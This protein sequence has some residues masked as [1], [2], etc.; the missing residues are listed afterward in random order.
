VLTALLAAGCAQPG[1]VQ[2]GPNQLAELACI[3]RCK[4]VQEACNEDA[5]YDY[6][7]CQAGYSQEFTAYR[8]CLASA[9]RPS[10]CGYPG[11][12]CAENFYGFCS[13]RASECARDCRGRP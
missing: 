8:W 7:Q 9:V 4:A 2:D 3:G 6:R 10:D 5:R 13:N 1:S 12:T 11:W